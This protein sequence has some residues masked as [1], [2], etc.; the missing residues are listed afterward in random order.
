MFKKLCGKLSNLIKRA[1]H[2][3]SIFLRSFRAGTNQSS[4]RNARAVFCCVQ[5]VGKLQQSVG[6]VGQVNLCVSRQIPA[7]SVKCRN[8]FF[9]RRRMVW[10]NL[11]SAGQSA[12]SV[13]SCWGRYNIAMDQ[14]YRRN[15]CCPSHTL[16]GQALSVVTRWEEW[17][18]V[19]NQ[20]QM[21]H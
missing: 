13:T 2:K 1:M 21:Y 12:G 17:T 19:K 5:H 18:L 16:G 8:P 15:C 4:H 20:A 14:N 10:R 3:I 9:P 6:S 11:I 7:D